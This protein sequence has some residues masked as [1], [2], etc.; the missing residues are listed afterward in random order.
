MIAVD[1]LIP[2]IVISLKFLFIDDVDILAQTTLI[3]LEHDDSV[4]FHIPFSDGARA[5]QVSMYTTAPSIAIVSSRARRA[6]LSG[7]HGIGPFAPSFDRSGTLSYRHGMT[8]GGIPRRDPSQK[9]AATL[10]IDRGE[11]MELI[12]FESLKNLRP[13]PP[14]RRRAQMIIMHK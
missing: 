13:D 6:R 7:D 10:G 11:Y 14:F 5:T 4:D 2:L 12:S 9:H 8:L 3:G 1:A